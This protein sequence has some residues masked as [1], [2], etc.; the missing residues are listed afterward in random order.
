ML[1]ECRTLAWLIGFNKAHFDAIPNW[2]GAD[3][4]LLTCNVAMDTH[5]MNATMAQK[6]ITIYICFKL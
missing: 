5:S 2:L 6:Y 3:N 4:C 1:V